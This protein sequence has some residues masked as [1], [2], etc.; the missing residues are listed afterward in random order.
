MSAIIDTHCHL[1]SLDYDEENIDE[2]IKNAKLSNVKYIFDIGYNMINNRRIYD[3]VLEHK[4]V[5]GM[6]G[7]HPDNVKE[8]TDADLREM[9]NLVS[10]SK[11][12]I[13]IGEI[14]LDYYHM[15]VSQELQKKYF[16]K[17]LR[18]AKK[19]K[20]PVSIHLRDKKNEY[21]VYEDCIKIL[22]TFN[23]SSHR[24]IKGTIHC[25]GGNYQLAKEFIALGMYIS[26]SGIVTFKNATA[27]QEVVT[28]IDIHHLLVET[29]APFLAPVPYRGHQNFPEYINYTIKKIAQLKSLPITSVMEMLYLNTLKVFK[30]N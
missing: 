22:K 2:I 14:G 1:S 27:L 30:I 12:I 24:Q 21:S 20:L 10:K 3:N 9:E 7:I 28:K 6:L 19:L 16:I 4:N 13:G 8:I 11:K 15:T 29:D 26:I 5:Y 17:Q 18:I 25:F 23:S